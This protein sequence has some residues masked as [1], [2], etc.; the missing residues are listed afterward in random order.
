[1]NVFRKI[2]VPTDFSAHAEEAARIA[3]DLSRCYGSSITLAYVDE[4]VLYALPESYMLF[5]AAQLA[6]MRAAYE[7]LLAAARDRALERG[8][9][10]VETELLHGFATS[11]ITNLARQG[12]YD[13]IVMGTHGRSGLE[14]LVIG[15]VAERV[16]QRAEC[17]VLTVR[18]PKEQMTA[19]AAAHAEP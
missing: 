3:V 8:A 19:A 5:T 1:M 7:H 16:V 14:H 11:E 9:K 10:A 15:S 13:L 12:G 17:P 18:L 2:L 4:P 6:E